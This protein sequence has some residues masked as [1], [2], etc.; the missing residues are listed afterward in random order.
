MCRSC[1]KKLNIFNEKKGITEILSCH[2][3]IVMMHVQW[4]P[5]TVARTN[6]Q[7]R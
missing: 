3:G 5:D 2:G 6:R 7:P 4:L 1:S